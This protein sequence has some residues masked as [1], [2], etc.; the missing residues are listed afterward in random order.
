MNEQKFNP[1][2]VPQSVLE[3]QRLH[4][5]QPK[6]KE[7]RF[8]SSPLFVAVLL[9]AG[10]AS[11]YSVIGRN[12]YLNERSRHAETL[13]KWEQAQDNTRD[14]LVIIKG[15]EKMMKEKVLNGR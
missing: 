6:P 9:W 2:D 3:Y 4:S 15:Y 8:P 10:V 12:A 13:V 1:S 7:Y 14:C 5:P 11:A